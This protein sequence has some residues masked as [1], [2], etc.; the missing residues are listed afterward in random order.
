M[1]ST[2]KKSTG[3]VS[4]TD[5]SLHSKGSAFSYIGYSVMQDYS[6]ILNFEKGRNH[7]PVMAQKCTIPAIVGKNRVGQEIPVRTYTNP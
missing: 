1:I 6:R 4:T 7:H 3:N 2:N 5:G